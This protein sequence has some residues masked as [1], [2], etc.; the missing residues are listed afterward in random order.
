MDA[1]FTEDIVKRILMKKDVSM[2]MDSLGR[3][4][5]NKGEHAITIQELNRSPNN[6]IPNYEFWHFKSDILIENAMYHHLRQILE[7]VNRE[8]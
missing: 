3:L 6:T 5:F 4:H 1:L 2:T 7:Y 8:I